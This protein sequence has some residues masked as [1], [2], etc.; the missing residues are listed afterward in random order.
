VDATLS[1]G[2]VAHRSGVAASA[3]RFYEAE[4]LI[5][6]TRSAGGQRQYHR[7]VLRRVAFIRVAQRVGLSLSEIRAAL[8]TLPERRTPTQADW[9]HLSQSWLGRLNDQIQLLVNMRD[10]LTSCIGCGCLSFRVCRMFNP[11]D[12]AGTLGDGPRYLLGDAAA[13]TGLG[14]G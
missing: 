6:S 1:I 12:V 8:S 10:R 14:S 9:E 4:G 11:D 5:G 2:E 3:L 13:D 7:E